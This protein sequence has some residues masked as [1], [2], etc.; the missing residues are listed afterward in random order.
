MEFS[1][2]GYLL[3]IENE[4]GAVMPKT[5]NTDCNIIMKAIQR[6]TLTGKYK[7]SS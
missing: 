2:R 5:A 6:Q 7:Y 3:D 1:G 4:M